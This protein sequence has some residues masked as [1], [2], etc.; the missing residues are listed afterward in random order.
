MSGRL[1]GRS[2]SPPQVN[3]SVS[4]CHQTTASSS[5]RRRSV[6]MDQPHG[7]FVIE[8][9][10]RPDH[11]CEEWWYHRDGCLANERFWDTTSRACGQ[12]HDPI[13]HKGEPRHEL[14]SHYL[15]RN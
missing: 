4:T 8:H 9:D 5:S 11:A 13:A 12:Q 3:G 6:A 7:R 14:T 15:S 1:R 2:R 10:E